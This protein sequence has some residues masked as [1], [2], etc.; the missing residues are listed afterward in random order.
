MEG[1][2]PLKMSLLKM[3]RKNEWSLVYAHM[4]LSFF[5]PASLVVALSFLSTTFPSFLSSVLS[6]MFAS[7]KFRIGY[8]SR[9]ARSSGNRI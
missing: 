5:I 8:H 7:V 9:R 6:N 1:F 2:T 3:C 4:I